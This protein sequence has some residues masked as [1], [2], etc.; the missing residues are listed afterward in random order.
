MN[1]SMKRP[2]NCTNII[3]DIIDFSKKTDVEQLEVK[4]QFN[5]LI[6]SALKDIAETD[7]T[8]LDT[9]NGAA[10]TFMAAPGRALTASHAIRDEVLKTNMNSLRPMHLR[11]VID[12]CVVCAQELDSVMPNENVEK[13]SL[14]M[15]K[16]EETKASWKSVA[17]NFAL[18]LPAIVTFAILIWTAPSLMWLFR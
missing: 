12:H 8:I 13:E 4:K 7:R 14:K 3:L 10:I 6:N 5:Y 2:Y 16:L 11:M 15:T 17:T 18:T 9:S 1:Q